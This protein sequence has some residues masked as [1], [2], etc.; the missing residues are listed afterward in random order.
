MMPCNPSIGGLAKGVVVREISALG[1]I[2]GEVADQSFLQTKMLNLRKGPGVWA[3]RNQID[4]EKYH[5]LILK[6]LKKLKNLTIKEGL[7]NWIEKYNL[8]FKL[9]TIEGLNLFCKKLIIT[10]GTYTSSLILQGKTKRKEGPRGLKTTTSISIFLKKHKVDLMR[11]KTGTPPRVKTSSL[12]LKKMKIDDGQRNYDWTF[13]IEK[14]LNK[15]DLPCYLTYTTMKT[16]EV[17]HKYLHTSFLYNQNYVIKGPARCPSIE[18][19][20]MRFPDIK[21]HRVFIEPN[22]KDYQLTY[23]Q[24]LSTSLSKE[25]QHELLKTIPGLEKAKIVKYAYAIE[26]DVVKPTQL[27]ATL[28]LK[29]HDGL[30]IAGQI[31]GSSGYEEA[32]GQGI[33]A[34]INASLSIKKEKELI[35]NEDESYIGRLINDMIIKGVTEP[36]RLLTS[37]MTYRMYVRSDNAYIRL[38]NIAKKYNLLSLKAQAKVDNFIEKEKQLNKLFQHINRKNHQEIFNYLSINFNIQNK[39]FLQIVKNQKINLVELINKFTIFKQL[40]LSKQELLMISINIKYKDYI[41]KEKI[42]LKKLKTMNNLRIPRN[43][44]YCSISGISNAAIDKL[45]HY[46]PQTI[47]QAK[48]LEKVTISDVINISN[49]IRRLNLIN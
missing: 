14:K 48:Q 38:N 5:F 23:L 16:K 41:E 20:V 15:I 12:N 37:M 44:D 34:G 45:K 8:G 35:L 10:T 25:A 32:A 27:K 43:I 22:D 40:N 24:G 4:R 28:E 49:Y 17:V 39:S 11:L 46:Q 6:E 7:V 18:D 3:I 13:G 9:K 2:M 31:N 42:I 21:S 26:Y 47:G 29:N 36:Y 33:I 30:Y 19:K 1:G